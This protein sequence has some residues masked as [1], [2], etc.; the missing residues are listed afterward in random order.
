M[1]ATDRATAPR[2]SKGVADS[3][4][5]DPGLRYYR[6][7]MATVT[8]TSAPSPEP[9]TEEEGLALLDEQAR[10]R[11]GMSADEFL[12]KWDAGEF[13]GREG[14]RPDIVKVAMLVPLAR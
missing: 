7:H 11:L 8:H 10:K 13:E 4:L 14:D 1:L 6:A 2:T 9:V 3:S 12:E 5:S